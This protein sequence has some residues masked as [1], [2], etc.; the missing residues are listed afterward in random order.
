MFFMY[1]HEAS[2]FQLQDEYVLYQS[3][4]MPHREKNSVQKLLKHY[5]SL[6]NEEDVVRDTTVLLHNGIFGFPFKK[7]EKRKKKRGS[8]N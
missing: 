1:L 3:S 7:I 5:E 2:R 6:I 8:N 4:L